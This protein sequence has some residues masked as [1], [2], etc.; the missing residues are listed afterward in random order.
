VSWQKS[1]TRWKKNGS[2]TA[3][4]SSESAS[5]SPTLRPKRNVLRNQ[6][7]LAPSAIRNVAGRNCLEIGGVWIDDGYEASMPTLVVRA[8]SPAYFKLLDRKPELKNLFRLGQHLLWV[9]PSKTALVIDTTDGKDQLSDPE[10]DALFLAK[11]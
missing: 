6:D 5:P 3:V 9:T 2:K 4:I 8:M 7:R 11:R 1:E 10:I